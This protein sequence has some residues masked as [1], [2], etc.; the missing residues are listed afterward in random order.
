MEAAGVEMCQTTLKNKS[1]TSEP[2]QPPR[3]RG[4]AGVLLHALL[5]NCEKFLNGPKIFCEYQ[6]PFIKM[7]IKRRQKT[8]FQ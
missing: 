6:L 8:E 4:R 5:I 1:V 7:A 3:P 2:G